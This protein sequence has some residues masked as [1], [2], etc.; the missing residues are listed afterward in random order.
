MAT[1]VGMPNLGHTMEEGTVVRWFKQEGESVARG[2]PL[3]DVES[4]K[5]V[6]TI[7][8]PA[9]G[10]LLKIAVQEDAIAPV[11]GA[12]GYIGE[13]GETIVE[14]APPKAQPAPVARSETPATVN[15]MSHQTLARPPAQP[16]PGGRP[17]RVRISPLARQLAMEHG[18]DPEQLVGTG[19]QGTISRDD[20]QA[21]LNQ[22]AQSTQSKASVASNGAQDPGLPIADRIPLTGMRRTIAQRMGQSWQQAPQVTVVLEADMS[23][24][25]RF[26]KAKAVSYNDL[27]VAAVAQALVEFPHLNAA[28][29][30]DCIEVYA[31]VNIGLAVAL[32]NGLVTPVLRGVQS[33]SLAEIAS[34]RR[35]LVD[36]ALAGR[37]AL[38][39]MAGGTFTISNLGGEGIH[40]FSPI[41]NPPQAAILG[42]GTIAP[43][44]VVIDGDIQARTM[45]ALSL[46]FDHRVIDGA[47]AA[48]FLARIKDLLEAPETLTNERPAT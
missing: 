43:R 22:R 48:R 40:F 4:D 32:E 36:K 9:A 26:R 25:D 17:Q 24:A 5:A 30:K 34:T 47:P 12:I 45:L 21:A 20:V 23:E 15:A 6:F 33:L 37:L 29:I 7:E 27:I 13:P 2:E 3:V 28:L 44:A 14:Q 35:R 31:T 10:V 16:S 41:V 18:L 11:G 42:V 19:P 39:D 8:A 46:T 38:D 1:I